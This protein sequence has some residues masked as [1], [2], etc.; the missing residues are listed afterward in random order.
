MKH[1]APSRDNGSQ[2]TRE[3]VQ[4][5]APPMGGQGALTLHQRF[6]TTAAFNRKPFGVTS[7]ATLIRL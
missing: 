4:A 6:F 5:A 2:N 3:L 1:E 7:N